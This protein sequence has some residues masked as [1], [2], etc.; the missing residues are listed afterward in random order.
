M[1][2]QKF[3]GRNQLLNR[4]ASQVG[5]V[6][7]AKS[8]L[9]KRGHMTPSGDLTKKGLARNSMTA[10]ERAIDRESR[11]TGQ[12]KSAFNYDPSTNRATRKR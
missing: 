10:A 3:M 12:P 7:S 2:T 9:I 4:L 1:T 5:S 6:A 8:I 11:A